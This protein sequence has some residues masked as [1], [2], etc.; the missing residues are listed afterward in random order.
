MIGEGNG[1]AFRQ[2]RVGAG[3]VK[4]LGQCV[5]QVQVPEDPLDD[6]GVVD[7]RDDAHRGAAA[8]TIERVDLVNVLNQLG[9]VGFAPCVDW[10]VVEF[11]P[12]GCSASAKRPSTYA[13]PTLV[14]KPG[15]S[16]V[17]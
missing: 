9:R 7:E 14:P 1:L 17:T 6:I 8:G 3:A 2:G 10:R 12:M 4:F 13:V 5:P 16:T 11:D 15:S